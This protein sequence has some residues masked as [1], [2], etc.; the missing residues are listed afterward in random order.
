MPPRKRARSVGGEASQTASD[1][2][3][4]GDAIRFTAM[5][6]LW[7][8]EMFLDCQ[9][10]VDGRCF[11]AHKVV[12]SAASAYMKAAFA[13]GLAE[14]AS[15]SVTLTEMHAA[16]FEAFLTWI[17]DGTVTVNEARLTSLLQV[18]IRLQVPALATEAETLVIARITPANA[19]GASLLAD[20]YDRA[21]LAGA[22][23][24]A[25]LKGF[26]EVATTDDFERLPAAALESLLS[27]D[28]LNVATEEDV[29]RALKRWHAAQRPAPSHE[30]S[31]RLL[32]L[33]R[34]ANLSK[35]FLR[36]HVNADPLVT[37]HL[38]VLT[39]AFQEAAFGSVPPKRGVHTCAFSAPFDT[40]GVL[41]HIATK[42]GT[43]PY[44]NPH[45]A[46]EVVSSTSS[47]SHRLYDDMRFVQHTHTEPVDNFTVNGESSWMA[48]D[49]G[50]GR[51]L[52]A[53]YYCL[54]SDADSDGAGCWM[55]NWELQG[56]NDGDE[57]A[58][59]RSHEDDGSL[60]SEA[61]ST[62][63]WTVDAAGRAFRR[64]RI[65]QTGPEAAGSHCLCCAGIELYGRI[66]DRPT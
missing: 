35:S 57:W 29:F 60:S 2:L 65:L 8:E 40:N 51:S 45:E 50:E 47:S 1:V 24:K 27:D 28:E 46:G 23:K 33:V 58:V 26:A 17:Y 62:A 30:T 14:S 37:R 22:A 43:R 10:H 21:R 64:F 5:A 13:S 3:V 15:A 16:D 56:S 34:W 25:M 49:L 59:L 12:L 66:R 61:M 38:I 18:A 11:S 42:G 9:V 36:E 63:A 6:Q 19:V 44:V 41:Y 48:V 31:A 20:M 7:R 39:E 55:R 54:R 52:V 4:A 32:R 53:D